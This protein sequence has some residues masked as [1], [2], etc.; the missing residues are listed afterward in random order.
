MAH[1]NNLHLVARIVESVTSKREAVRLVREE[2]N[3]LIEQS[4]RK[5]RGFDRGMYRDDDTI[6]HET[7]RQR[8]AYSVDIAFALASKFAD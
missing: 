5:A 4:E 2:A 8:T 3:A 6:R 1:D 7:I